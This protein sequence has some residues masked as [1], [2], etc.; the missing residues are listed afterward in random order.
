MAPH[1]IA[2]VASP[3]GPT[4]SHALA[5]AALLN[6]FSHLALVTESQSLL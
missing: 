1:V 5:A 3:H 2:F 6:H 4:C